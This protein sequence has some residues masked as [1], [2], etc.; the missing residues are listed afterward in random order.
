MTAERFEALT[1]LEII[2]GQA[3][4]SATRGAKAWMLANNP[5]PHSIPGPVLAGKVRHGEAMVDEFPNETRQLISMQDRYGDR[6]AAESAR[7]AG[8]RGSN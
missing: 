8:M 1:E 6:W 7:R 4:L 5:D 2:L 3:G